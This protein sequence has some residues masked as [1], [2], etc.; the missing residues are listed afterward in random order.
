MAT[1]ENYLQKA[2][3]QGGFSSLTPD[4][5]NEL[6]HLSQIAENYEDSIPLMP[7]RVPQGIP[8][9]ISFKMYELKINQREM[10]Q[11]LEIAETR[12]SEILRGKRR[13]S[14]ELAKQLRTK[15]GIDAD[16]I[17]EYA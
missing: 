1:I 10:A 11:L 17:L 16:F 13:V 15:L 6:A 7:I 2:T 3:A 14:L 9:M 5:A 4:E 8:E 12:L